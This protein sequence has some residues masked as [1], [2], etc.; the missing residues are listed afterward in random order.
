MFLRLPP[1]IWLSLVLLCLSGACPSCDPGCVR[2]PP[3][4]AVSVILWFWDPVI[5]GVSKLLGVKLPLG[6]WDPGVTKLLGSW[7]PGCVRAPGRRAASGCCGAGCQVW[8]QGLLRAPAQT[9]RKR[10]HRFDGVPTCLGPTG[11]SYSQYWDRGCVL[12]TSDSLI[13]A[14]WSAWEWSYLRVMWGWL[15]S[16]HPISTE[17]LGQT[18]WKEPVP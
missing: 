18:D 4:Q 1:A 5:L 8:P 13:W 6:S 15:L 12:L 14:C 17:G 2:T 3:S 11:S 10:C 7:D 9:W 16:L